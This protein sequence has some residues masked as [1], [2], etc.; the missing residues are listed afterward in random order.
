[1][2]RVAHEADDRTDCALKVQRAKAV[3]RPRL[4]THRFD[5]LFDLSLG[6]RPPAGSFHAREGPIAK[7]RSKMGSENPRM[8]AASVRS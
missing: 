1:M 8:R 4:D 2:R 7:L 5:G 6:H 3:W